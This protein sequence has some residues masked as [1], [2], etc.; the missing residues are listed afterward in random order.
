MR[1]LLNFNFKVLSLGSGGADQLSNDVLFEEFKYIL[2]DDMG[3][4]T[5]FCANFIILFNKR[6]RCDDIVQI[7]NQSNDNVLY[8]IYI[9]FQFNET[10]F[11]ICKELEANFCSCIFYKVKPV[12]FFKLINLNKIKI[13]SPSVLNVFSNEEQYVVRIKEF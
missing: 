7:Y 5:V 8:Q 10:F 9:I 11:L 2:E 1:F 6:Y 12:K 4:E 13:S 3:K